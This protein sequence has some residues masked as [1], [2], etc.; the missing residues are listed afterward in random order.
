MEPFPDLKTLTLTLNPESLDEEAPAHRP[1]ATFGA[2]GDRC[3]AV[4]GGGDSVERLSFSAWGLGFRTWD[5]ELGLRLQAL[6]SGV[7]GSKILL[8]SS[9]ST[10]V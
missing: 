9:T 8:D 3:Q 6:G 2:L 1:A 5:L 10:T 4:G 7:S